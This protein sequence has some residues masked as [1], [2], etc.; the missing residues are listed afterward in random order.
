MRTAY[1]YDERFLQ[2]ETG[3]DEHR[4][5]DGSILEPIEHPSS[6][7]IIRRTAQLIA[8]SGLLADA[9]IVPA[10][11]AT[12]A[13][14][15]AYH[16]PEYIAHVQRVTAEGGGWLDPETPVAPGSWDAALLAAGAAIELTNAVLDGHARHAFGL[17]RPPG[18]HAMRAQ[19]MGFCVFNNVVI[20]VRHAQ[21]RGIQRVM[22]LDWDVHH[23]NGTQDAFGTTHQSCSSRSIK[24]TGIQRDGARSTMSVGRVQR[25]QPSTSHSHPALETGV[26]S[27]HWSVLSYQSPGSS[28]PRWSSSRLGRTQAWMTRWDAC[29]SR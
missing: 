2:H 25:E 10:R 7:R 27:S 23:G 12:E 1:C 28:V 24:R 16:T 8:S 5:P 17:L 4:L 15:T 20:A 6:A 13:E 3:L 18:H 14:L 26:T 11:P 9:L 21:R 29:W 19:G 22:V